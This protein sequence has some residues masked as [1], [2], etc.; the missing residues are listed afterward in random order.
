[1]YIHQY[2]DYLAE[3]YIQN[4]GQYQ[5]KVNGN[6]ID[7][8]QWDMVYNG[9]EL[10]LEAKRNNETVY[11]NLNNND[12]MK[13]LAVPAHHKPI[14]HRLNDDLQDK[15]NI[16]IRPIVIEELEKLI[17]HKKTH[18][19]TNTRQ[20]RKTTKKLRK[21]ES[22]SKSKSKSKTK[23]KSKSK[24]NSKTKSKSKSK[25]IREVTPDFMKT[26]Y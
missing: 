7:N 19:T 17:S 8:T 22:K 23:S 25:S 15:Q 4:K 9:E 26:I 24:T 5:T 16:D 13:L 14:H 21:D 18:G 1:M 6:I 10:D 20:K 11:M 12:I 3:N 2:M